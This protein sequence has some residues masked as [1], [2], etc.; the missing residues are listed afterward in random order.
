M[1]NQIPQNTKMSLT[2]ETVKSYIR[3]RPVKES[4][5]NPPAFIKFTD[6]IIKKT[7]HS[8]EYPFSK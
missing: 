3:I 8:E 1:L 2:E 4:T 6:T 5:Q 7:D